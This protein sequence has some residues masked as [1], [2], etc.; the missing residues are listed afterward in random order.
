MNKVFLIG[1]LTK[2]PEIRVTTT[3]KK[4][5]NFTLAINDGK[6]SSGQELTTFMN[7]IAWERLAEI[8]E[9]Y[10]KKGVKVCVIGSIRNRSWD[11]PD[12]SKG[13]ATEVNV[14][15]MEIL[16]TKA[17][18]ANLEGSES[19]NNS[20]DSSSSNSQNQSNQD[21]GTDEDKK[22][23]KKKSKSKDEEEKLPEINVDDL[24]VQMPF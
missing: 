5:C 14:R 4:V 18:M 17:E 7:C 12:G 19:G 3:G 6:D 9:M 20:S 24:N 2:D 1:R 8:L 13:Y 23:S 22:K 16:T 11:K 15:E 21:E 10:V